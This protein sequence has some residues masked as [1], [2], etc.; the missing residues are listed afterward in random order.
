METTA[1]LNMPNFSDHGWLIED[2]QVK[3]N[4]MSLPVAPDSILAFVKCS[5]RKGCS[6]NRCS[7]NKASLSCSDLCNCNECENV[8][9]CHA[10][11]NESEEADCSDEDLND[12]GDEY[13]ENED[14]TEEMEI[15]SEWET[16]VVE[17]SDD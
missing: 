7:C 10:E 13:E 9:S 2:N 3:V 16:S 6:N 12:Y 11:D 1:L 4:W 5:C 8:E 15:A 17:S 14:D